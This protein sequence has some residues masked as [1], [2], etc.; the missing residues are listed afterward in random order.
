MEVAPRTPR[1][2]AIRLEEVWRRA[3]QKLSLEVL[4][5]VLLIGALVVDEYGGKPTLS[6]DLW[7]TAQAQANS[8]RQDFIAGAVVY[9]ETTTLEDACITGAS[10][11]FGS[12]YD[13]ERLTE[14]FY[15]SS[16]RECE[17]FALSL[18]CIVCTLFLF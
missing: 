1:K 17:S 6:I 13:L 4:S 18:L 2:A 10:V 7:D 12:G 15:K 8:T 3:S 11:G 14:L 9:F 5:F 16:I